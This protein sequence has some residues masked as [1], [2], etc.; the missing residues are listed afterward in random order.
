MHSSGMQKKLAEDATPLAKSFAKK[1]VQTVQ[2]LNS[3]P[4]RLQVI[5]ASPRRVTLFHNFSHFLGISIKLDGSFGVLPVPRFTTRLI[6]LFRTKL[7]PLSDG[8]IQTARFRPLRR[9]IEDRRS[10]K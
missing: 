1:L 2:R 6:E 8:L 5:N 3:F 9:P 7:E 10:F 4:N